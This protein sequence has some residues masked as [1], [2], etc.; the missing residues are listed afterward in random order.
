MKPLRILLALTLP[1]PAGAA[2]AAMARRA[3]VSAPTLPAGF[4]GQLPGESGPRLELS[5]PSLP[6]SAAAPAALPVLEAARAP[7]AALPV[8]PVA[9]PAAATERPPRAALTAA[10]AP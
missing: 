2:P 6:L 4:P 10:A 1:C 8:L 7:A 5:L 3:A 9:A